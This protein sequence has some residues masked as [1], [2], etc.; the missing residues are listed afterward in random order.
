MKAIICYLSFSGNTKEVSEIIRDT[1]I[2]DGHEVDM[3]EIGLGTVPDLSPY[4]IIFLGTFTWNGGRTPDDVKEFILEV[5]YKPENIAI[6]G[7][8]DTQFGDD[9]IY[10]GAVNRL[11]K[12]YNSKFEPLKI[13]Q[14]PRGHQEKLVI[15]WTYGVIDKWKNLN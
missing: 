12:F 1:L 2:K 5:G 7:T 6:F 15:E 9:T 8:G 4:D 10:C 11:V 13:E 3:Y 14:S